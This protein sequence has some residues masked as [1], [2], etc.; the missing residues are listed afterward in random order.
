MA[1]HKGC[2][3]P[4]FAHPCEIQT[5]IALVCNLCLQGKLLKKFSVLSLLFFLV[6]GLV[7][8]ADD[9]KNQNEFRSVIADT[10]ID[11][12]SRKHYFYITPNIYTVRVAGLNLCSEE[13]ESIV[14]QKPPIL[15]T[16]SIF[17]APKINGQVQGFVGQPRG[18]QMSSFVPR[19]LALLCYRTSQ[20]F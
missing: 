16:L 1:E 10:V 7:A 20:V 3:P 9:T 8:L 18:A 4:C 17:D 11:V 15:K 19:M 6:V 2:P 14:M 13:L 12:N 5:S